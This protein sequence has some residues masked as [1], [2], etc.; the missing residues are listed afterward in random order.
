MIHAVIRIV[1]LKFIEMMNALYCC[2]SIKSNNNIFK[3][4]VYQQ[5]KYHRFTR[6]LKKQRY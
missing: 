5:N 4:I 6:L 3:R 1:T 2:E